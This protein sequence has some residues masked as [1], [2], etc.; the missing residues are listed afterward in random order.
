MKINGYEI[1]PGANL[2]DANLTYTNLEGANLEGA[3][4]THANL[5]GANLTDANLEGA[6][7][8]DANL[9]GAN[10]T[11]ANLKGAN[12]ADAGPSTAEKAAY[13]GI[14]IPSWR[15]TAAIDEREALK[16]LK[17]ALRKLKSA[18]LT[19]A[20]MPDGSIHK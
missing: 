9:K 2:E 8:T 10:L 12:L 17:V 18:K 20:T 7:L 11:H 6:N 19:G 16:K 15:D 1:G 4:L 5:K 13:W 14:A 3:N